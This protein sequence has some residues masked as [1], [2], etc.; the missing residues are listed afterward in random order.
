MWRNGT[1]HPIRQ[2]DEIRDESRYEMYYINKCL[3]ALYPDEELIHDVEDKINEVIDRY[4]YSN[5]DFSKI[6]S[7]FVNSVFKLGEH[8]SQGSWCENCVHDAVD[9]ETKCKEQ[10][11]NFFESLNRDGWTF[12]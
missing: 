6:P 8:I 7:T 11:S 2:Y 9:Y 10:L 1:A 4:H 12:E 5:L 3:R